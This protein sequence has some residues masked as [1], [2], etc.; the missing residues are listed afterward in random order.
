MKPLT[1]KQKE[2]AET[3]KEECISRGFCSLK[4][5]CFLMQTTPNAISRML[6]VLSANGIAY[7]ESNGD[8]RTCQ[9]TTT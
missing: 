9:N 4:M 7:R 5:A 1:K 6:M 8:M 3:I 2:L